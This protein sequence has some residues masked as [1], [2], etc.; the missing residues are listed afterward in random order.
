MDSEW[1]VEEREEASKKTANLR[2]GTLVSMMR[3]LNICKDNNIFTFKDFEYIGK[4]HKALET[5]IRA[6]LEQ[7]R[8]EIQGR[9]A[10]TTVPSSF[11]MAAPAFTPIESVVA[12]AAPSTAA[13]PTFVEVKKEELQAPQEGGGTTTV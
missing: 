10:G 5:A 9:Y 7:S 3:L 8:L 12:P 1:T 4:L 13:A 11:G 6:A 2:V